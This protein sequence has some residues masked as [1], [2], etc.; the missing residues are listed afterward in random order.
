MAALTDTVRA[1]A[2]QKP[3]SRTQRD[4][5]PADA[6]DSYSAKHLSVLEGLDAVRKRPGMYIGSTDGRGLQHCL[7]EIFDNAVDEALGGYCTRVEVILHADGSAEVLDNGRGIPVDNERKTKLSG[8]ELVMTRLHAGGKFGGGSYTASG[9][10]HGVGASVVN[11][12]S[13][14]LEIDVDEEGQHLVDQLPAR[15]GRRVRCRRPGRRLR[16]QVGPA[17]DG[18]GAADADGHQDQVLAGPPGVPAR[19]NVL[20]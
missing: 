7:W 3:R 6:T 13:L 5:P 20:L 14:R 1:T 15:R 16:A 8:V 4:S 10:L 19:R 9:G 12:L 11:A 18:E 17:P 2:D